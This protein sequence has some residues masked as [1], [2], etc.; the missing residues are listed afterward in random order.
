ML[1]QQNATHVC[2]PQRATAG[3]FLQIGR[4][5]WLKR[6][7]LFGVER[8]LPASVHPPSPSNRFGSTAPPNSAPDAATTSPDRRLRR[9]PARLRLHEPSATAG[10]V[11][12][13]FPRRSTPTIRR[14]TGRPARRDHRLC[15]IRS[16]ATVFRSECFHGVPAFLGGGGM[17]CML[18]IILPESRRC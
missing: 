14:P 10:D 8:Q 2:S 1:F 9:P 15:L 13:A 17:A 3:V 18:E 6:G 11:R 16:S 7:L 5:A 12:A 4:R